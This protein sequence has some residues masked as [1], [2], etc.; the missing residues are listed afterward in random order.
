MEVKVKK[1]IFFG[2]ALGAL[3]MAGGMLL[4]F[5]YL[6]NTRASAF[7]SQS[8]AAA[9]WA[10]V[11][12]VVVILIGVALTAVSLFSSKSLGALSPFAFRMIDFAYPL[13]LGLA[14]AVHFDT[15]LVRRSY[16]EVHNQATKFCIAGRKIKKIMISEHLINL[17]IFRLKKSD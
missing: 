5:W 15:D 17:R 3:L 12:L 2:L 11:F 14:K 10:A 8:L 16:V 6:S 9:G 7:L 4:V 13:A 1:R